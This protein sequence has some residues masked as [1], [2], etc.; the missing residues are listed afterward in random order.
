MAKAHP[1]Q[2]AEEIHQF[3]DLLASFSRLPQSKETSHKTFF[4][5][6]GISSREVC[7]SSFLAFFLNP[8]EEHGFGDLF[9]RALVQASGVKL[10]TKDFAYIET[11][12]QTPK[13]RIDLVIEGASFVLGIENKI[14][15]DLYNN[16][17]D[18][19][20]H[21][22]VLA[23]QVEPKK[24]V[25]ALVLS[26]KNERPPDGFSPVS[27]RAF[28]DEIQKHLGQKLPLADHRAITYLTDFINSIHHLEK[29]IRMDKA[30]LDFFK[31]NEQ[32]TLKL[33]QKADELG[34]MLRAKVKN[35]ENGVKPPDVCG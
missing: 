9:L 18:Y 13:G 7:Y 11:E 31:E 10:D 24:T 33:A 8:K 35:V 3:K 34:Q 22:E 1:E 4:E 5:I 6:C 23:K 14:G 19:Y 21:L 2:D 28:I 15:A 12:V 20:Q 25:L 27:Y 29:G 30:Q 32:A 16:L 17:Q 26:I